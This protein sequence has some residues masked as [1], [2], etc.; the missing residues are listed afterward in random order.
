VIGARVEGR[1]VQVPVS[2]SKRT[3][4]F[5]RGEDLAGTP[6]IQPDTA[7]ETTQARCAA[8]STA[9]SLSV[10]GDFAAECGVHAETKD[11][12]NWELL[13]F[14]ANAAKAE[15][16]QALKEAHEK[17]GSPASISGWHSPPP[18]ISCAV[19]DRRARFGEWRAR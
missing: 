5:Q 3:T 14:A 17:A 16:R 8:R 11:H 15:L 18:P 1:P 7:I 2:Y 12:L 6:P 4:I 10:L 9:A 19:R 13:G